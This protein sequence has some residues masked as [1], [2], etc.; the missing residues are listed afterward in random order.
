MEKDF[1]V[2][3]LCFPNQHYM[4]DMSKKL[5][6]TVRMVDKGLYFIINRPRQYGK[7]TMLYTLYDVLTQTGTYIVFNMSFEG[8]GNSIFET[9]KSFSQGFAGLLGKMVKESA[10]EYAD[11]YNDTAKG[12]ENLEILSE[13]ITKLADKAHKNLVLMID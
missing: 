10:S 11:W 2:T 5:G 8:I 12:T 9:E 3:G 6:Q 1:N 4:A 13:L 7:T